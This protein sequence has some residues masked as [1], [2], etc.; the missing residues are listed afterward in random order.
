M[1]DQPKRPVETPHEWLRY[2]EGDLNV[3]KH[4]MQNEMPV[5]HTVCFLCQSAAEKFLKGFLIARG[6]Q[7]ERSHDI[8]QLLALCEDYDTELGK[9]HAEGAILNEYIIGGRY[10]GD[11]ATES[12]GEDEAEEALA[13]S[14][15]IRDRVRDLLPGR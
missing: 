2:A 15:R 3:A 13:A 11:I 1:S 10:P 8:V 6:W 5:Y 7:L 9:M 12:I 14:Q 4:E